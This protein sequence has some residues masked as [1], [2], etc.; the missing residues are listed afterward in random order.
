MPSDKICKT[1][2]QYNREPIPREYMEKLVE[3]AEDYT[4]VKNY[5][6]TRFGGIGSLSKLYPGYMV[7]NEMTQSGLR[8]QLQMP[9]VYFYLAV[10]EAL[11]DIKSQWSN[12]RAR[13]SKLVGQNEG[14][15]EDEKHYLRFLLKVT[16]AFDAALNERPITL[17]R[18]IQ[19]QYDCLAGKVD[20]LKMH[21]YVRRQVRK[22]HVKLRATEAG[23]FSTAGKA[24]RYGDHGIYISIKEKRKRIFVPLTDNNQYDRQL[25]IKLIPEQ[26]N[27]EIKVPI[28]VAVR[29]YADYTGEIGLSLGMQVMLTTDEGHRY[30]ER[31][32][33]YQSSYADWIR[34]QTAVYNRNRKDNPGRKKY[35]ARKSQFEEQLHSYINQELNRFFRT[36]KPRILYLPRLPRSMTG[37][38]SK[39]INH[40]AALWQR[41][42]IRKRLAQKCEE[43]SV[44]LV[45]VWGKDISRECSR[46]GCIVM[47]NPAKQS[48][49]FHCPSCGFQEE[50][51]TNTARNAKKRGQGEGVLRRS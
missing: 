7:Q 9:S 19:A 40:Y 41:G 6:Y 37:G 16:N 34:E 33:E 21:R 38:V 15:T 11:G 5:V 1:I 20:V 23:G 43:Q 42:Y 24:Y 45:E 36:E 49:S 22:Y 27:L 3:I 35:N 48:G 32:G 28:D 4:K 14:F 26:N 46:C 12:I 44:E 29:S 30:G 17:Q 2:H 39:R 13:I 18:D 10:F 25:Y 47:G 50:E 31:L 8:G 51:K